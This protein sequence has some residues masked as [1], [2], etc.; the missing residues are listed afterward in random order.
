MDFKEV[1]TQKNERIF[2][3]FSLKKMLKE[4][5]PID[6]MIYLVKATILILAY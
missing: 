5:K 2:V 3:E 1:R 4:F 6:M